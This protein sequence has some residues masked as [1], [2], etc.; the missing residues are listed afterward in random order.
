V[1]PGSN[2]LFLNDWVSHDGGMF[3]ALHG[4]VR[5]D[6]IVSQGCRAVGRPMTVT[7]AQANMLVELDTKPALQRMQEVLAGLTDEERRQTSAGL[8]IGR[9]VHPDAAGR[10][11]YVVRNVLGADRQRGVVAVADVV[12]D[13]ERI[14]LHVRDGVTAREDLDLLLVPQALDTRAQA[15]LVFSCNGRGTHLYDA[16][17]GDI[18]PLQ[19]ALGGAVPAAGFF[20]AGEIGPVGAANYLHGHTASIAIIRSA[21][22]SM[23]G[24][25]S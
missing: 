20:C 14:R 17:N 6:V 25:A 24:D 4:A 3:L 13:G 15:A 5:A 21:R 2:T 12:A 18:V 23:E 10:G 8:F 16:P 9:P 19:A 22:A 7:R 1:R 11:D